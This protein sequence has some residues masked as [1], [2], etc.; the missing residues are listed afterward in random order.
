MPRKRRSLPFSVNPS[1]HEGRAPAQAGVQNGPALSTGLRPS[2]EHTHSPDRH[3][4]RIVT[5][6]YHSK[7]IYEVSDE[8]IM[9]LGIYRYQD[10][11]I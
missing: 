10:R 9:I 11:K 3:F 7:L 8:R 2:P 4:R 6:Q 5:I 1:L